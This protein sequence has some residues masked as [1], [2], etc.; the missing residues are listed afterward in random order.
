MELKLEHLAVLKANEYHF[1][2]A[3]DGWVQNVTDLDI[4]EH[5]YHTY[6][7]NRFILTKWCKGCVM[8]M[9]LRLGSFYEQNK[10][11]ENTSPRKP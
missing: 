8:N 6:L 2:T 9:M 7:D 11:N 1:A 10:P 3:K 4:L 5:I